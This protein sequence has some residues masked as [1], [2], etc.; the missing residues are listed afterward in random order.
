MRAVPMHN[1]V[2]YCPYIIHG[3]QASGVPVRSRCSKLHCD[4][5]L[6]G[7]SCVRGGQGQ[8]RAMTARNATLGSSVKNPDFN[9]ELAGRVG[10]FNTLNR[11]SRRAPQHRW[12][13]SARKCGG[14]EMHLD[15]RNALKG[16]S[17]RLL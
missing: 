16:H 14:D 13:V 7:G 5:A 1:S 4:C 8:G 6:V 12:Y 2:W 9:V 3:I 10:Q 15:E 17:A 11:T